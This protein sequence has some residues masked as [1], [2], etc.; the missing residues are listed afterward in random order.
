M[1]HSSHQSQV[2][3]IIQSHAWLKFILHLPHDTNHQK[4]SSTDLD[5]KV[6][7]SFEKQVFHPQ[8]QF[9]ILELWKEGFSLHCI[10]Y[11]CIALNIVH[12]FIHLRGFI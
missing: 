10:K 2:N 11:S 12:E 4:Q 1:F 7:F 6:E 5:W 8:L 9:Y 3:L